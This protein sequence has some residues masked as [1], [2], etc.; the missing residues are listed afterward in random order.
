MIFYRDCLR[1]EDICEEITFLMFD[2]IQL[3]ITVQNY[4]VVKVT[5]IMTQLTARKC[6]NII[7]HEGKTKMKLAAS[8]IL[9]LVVLV[10]HTDPW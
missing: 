5:E 7:L 1:K 4:G 9:T 2:S 8:T 6:T 3:G 10:I